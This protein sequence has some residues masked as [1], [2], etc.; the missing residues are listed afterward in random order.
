MNATKRKFIDE[1]YAEMRTF[2]FPRKGK[3]RIYVRKEADIQKVKDIIREMDENEYD[4]LPDDL[5][6][7][8][9]QY[10]RLVYVG[11]FDELPIEALTAKCWAD[12]VPI[13]CVC[14]GKGQA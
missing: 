4:Y 8:A 3:G 14:E 11:K 5:I 1:V 9:D 13:W 7:T 12:G 6:T 10:P 2:G